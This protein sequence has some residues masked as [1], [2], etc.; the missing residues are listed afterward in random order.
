MFTKEIIEKYI[1]YI[2]ILR[3]GEY[4][5]ISQLEGKEIDKVKNEYRYKGGI[6]GWLAEKLGLNTAEEIKLLESNE[7]V[8]KER[9]RIDSIFKK[10]SN[11]KSSSKSN[12]FK[13]NNFEEFYK[14]YNNENNKCCY[15]GVEEKYLEEYFN[16]KNIQYYR[17]DEDKARQRGQSLELE[18]II[19]SGYEKNVYSKD[20]CALACYIC[21]NAKSDFLSAKNFKPIAKG[22]NIFW[23]KLLNQQNN[24]SDE[25][26]FNSIVKFPDTDN[27][28]NKE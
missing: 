5:I 8:K 20:N 6:N 9:N 16:Q 23:N 22:I 11:K 25:E 3:I 12:E 28:W 15:C 27:I 13:F 18:R 21:N 17:D 1:E 14:C 4:K 19:T 7:I 26:L 10:Y 24:L 2:C